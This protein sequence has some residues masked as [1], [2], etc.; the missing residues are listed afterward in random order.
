MNFK[1]NEEQRMLRDA[2]REF[3]EKEIMPYGR[4]YDEKKEYPWEIFRKAAKLGF[5]GIDMPEEY[6]GA[7]MEY[8]NVAI[9]AEELTRADSSIG[10]AI[11][12]SILGCPMLKYFGSDEQK[13][14]YLKP[15]LEGKTTSAIAITEPDAGS[16][17]NAIRT[18]AEKSN[19]GWV[20]NDVKT[21]ITNGSISDWTILIAKTSNIT[22]AHKSM[23]AFV[24]ETGWEG[25]DAKP[26]EK[27]GLN[28]HDTAEVFL[29]NLFIPESNLVG[30]LN[31]GF[32]QLMHFF[33]ESRVLV[34]AIQLGIAIGA[35]ER[36]LDYAKQ[37]KAFGKPLI[38][39]Q[40]IQ[41][42]LADMWTEIE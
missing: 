24:V 5:I 7:G 42:K 8:M 40:A 20:V 35:Y 29:K 3:A 25:Y 26:I 16:D 19:N 11:A 13:E 1:F 28:C 37:R 14:K 6:G 9:V 34:A 12:S 38:E 22:L 4:E 23:S 18:K 36:A 27:M 32:Y 41:F 2:V 31:K 39:H 15:V 17:V 10:S 33:N 30:E 21:F